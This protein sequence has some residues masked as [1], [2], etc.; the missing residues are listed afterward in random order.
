MPVSNNQTYSTAFSESAKGDPADTRRGRFVAAK[1]GCPS[2][3]PE[4]NAAV[5]NMGCAGLPVAENDELAAFLCSVDADNEFVVKQT[6][7]ESAYEITQLVM[8]QAEYGQEQGPYI[9]KYLQ[10]ESGLGAAYGKLYQAQQAGA[11]FAYLP[12]IY[13]CNKL[14]NQ[15]VVVVEYVHGE[16]LQEVVHRLGPS[17]ALASDVM[18]RV[19]AAARELHEGFN[20]PVIHRDLKPSNI[21]LSQQRLALIDFGIARVYN[22][23][24]DQDTMRF[25]TR[26]Y[27]PP[28]QFGFGQTDVR[29]DVYSLGMLLFYCLTGR[30][31]T[32]QD[33]KR[34]FADPTVPE[35][36]RAIIAKACSFDPAD[37]YFSAAELQKAI[38]QA[39][40]AFLLYEQ[41]LSASVDPTSALQ[42]KNH[43]SDS[44]V[45]AIRA[46][47][48]SFA[49]RIPIGIGIAWN[50]VLF[51]AWALIFA[52][53]IVCCVNINAQYT[54]AAHPVWLRI[55]EYPLFVGG[56]AACILYELSDRR[57]LR[58]RFPWMKQWPLWLEFLVIALAVP[59]ALCAV[60]LL[61][62]QFAGV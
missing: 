10:L 17:T 20:P 24:S 6:L 60:M 2:V 12:K 41:G 52:A 8:R 7:K 31:A 21:I 35:C 32:A 4:R 61:C 19:C 45:P 1:D 55:V 27:A 38:G 39:G 54:S 29:S 51:V 18:M 30:S 34:E 33:R 9:R 37:R 47:V 42:G 50:V 53:C 5:V 56:S 40:K 11:S 23:E 46:A 58:R 28:E 62:M 43:C 13:S 15:L 36:F 14:K 57:L 48:A 59:A 3:L 25:G 16:T 26:S 22:E 44:E 49:N